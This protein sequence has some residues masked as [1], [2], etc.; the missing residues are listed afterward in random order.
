MSSRDL[1]HSLSCGGS[2][3]LRVW[4]LLTLRRVGIKY[5]NELW[6]SSDKV[7]VYTDHGGTSAWCF[8]PDSE[9]CCSVEMA[10]LDSMNREH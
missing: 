9:L 4:D 10:S 5:T 8:V 7:R 6:S 1:M 3:Q 2:Q